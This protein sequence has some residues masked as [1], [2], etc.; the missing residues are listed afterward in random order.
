MLNDFP[1]TAD[2]P[3]PEILQKQETGGNKKSASS[4]LM[5]YFLHKFAE[6]KNEPH[7]ALLAVGDTLNFAAFLID[8]LCDELTSAER[9]ME[10]AENAWLR[11]TAGNTPKPHTTPVECST[12]SECTLSVTERDGMARAIAYFEARSAGRPEE[13]HAANLR[14]I[15]SRLGGGNG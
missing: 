4:H 9:H 5:D 6:R 2:F 12:P 8:R 11:E 7:N 15:M 14:G 3:L 10:L 13:A 1:T